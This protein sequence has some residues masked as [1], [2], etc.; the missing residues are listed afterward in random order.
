MKWVVSGAGLLVVGTSALWTVTV[1]ADGPSQL[2]IR[3]VMHKE[4]T[5]KSSPFVRIKTELNT[6]APDWE[7]VRESTRKFVILAEALRENEPVWGEEESWKR[8]TG[9]HLGD[10]QAMDDAAGA[11]DPAAVLVV[12][13][14]LASSCK[15]CHDAHRFRGRD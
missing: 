15:A 12:H 11:R 3:A 9:L 2:S 10:A 7:K 1:G 5:V 8:F 14:R 4:Y 13:Q 6:E